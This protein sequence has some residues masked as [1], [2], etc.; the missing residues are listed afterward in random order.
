MAPH[1]TQ[2]NATMC[3]LSM[4]SPNKPPR[5]D[6]RAC[7]SALVSMML[8]SCAGVAFSDCPIN[9]YAAQHA[10]VSTDNSFMLKSRPWQI[11]MYALCKH[12]YRGKV[13]NDIMAAFDQGKVHAPKRCS[14]AR[15]WKEFDCCCRVLRRD[16]IDMKLGC[17]LYN[18]SG[19]LCKNPL[20]VKRLTCWKYGL[21]CLLN[22]ETQGQGESSTDLPA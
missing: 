12:V 21:I 1:S 8:P 16:I 2:P 17:L 14:S 3:V 11:K 22:N 4:R 13:T 9:L 15:A 20:D 18:I 19:R 10:E 7:T 6:E 5:G